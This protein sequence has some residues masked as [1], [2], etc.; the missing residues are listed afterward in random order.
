VWGQLG[1]IVEDILANGT[2]FYA[3]DMMVIPERKGFKEET[4]WTFSY[5]PMPDD[6]GRVNGIFCACSDVTAKVLSQRRLNTL[7]QLSE[8]ST[9][10]KPWKTS[11]RIPYRCSKGN[12]QTCPLPLCTCWTLKKKRL[13]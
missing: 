13:P 10:G 6:D 7:H 11:V 1:G 9:P 5:S 3:E 2:T 8:G 12:P 4:Y